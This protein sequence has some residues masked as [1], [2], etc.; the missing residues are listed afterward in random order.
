MQAITLQAFKE[1]HMNHRLIASVI[2][3]L[4]LSACAAGSEVKTNPCPTGYKPSQN[5]C[6]P[7]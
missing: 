6:I 7:A 4:L 1:P 3:C 5:Y 2:A